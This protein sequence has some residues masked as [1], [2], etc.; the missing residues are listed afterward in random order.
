MAHLLG[1][2]GALDKLEA[3]VSSNGRTFYQRPVPA[4]LIENESGEVEERKQTVVLRRA[5]HVVEDVWILG[6]DSVVPFWA[7]RGLDWE[8]VQD[9]N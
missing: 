6:E 9:S 4:T 8:I 2:F 7:G 5:K 1:S 3:F